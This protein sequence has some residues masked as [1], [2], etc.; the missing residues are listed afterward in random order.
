M[1]AINFNL[2][3]LSNFCSFSVARRL[4]VGGVHVVLS[5]ITLATSVLD[6]LAVLRH[7][8]ILASEK[9]VINYR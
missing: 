1:L 4:G 5:V 7:K 2:F 6:W 3:L 9:T 8:S